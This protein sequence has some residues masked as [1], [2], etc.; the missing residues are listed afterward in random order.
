MT[1]SLPASVPTEGGVECGSSL[2]F[3]YRMQV[4]RTGEIETFKEFVDKRLQFP[5]CEDKQMIALYQ[6]TT[7]NCSLSRRSLSLFP[8]SSLH[9]LPRPLF[10][11]HLP[12]LPSWNDSRRA[13]RNQS[14]YRHAID[15]Y[16]HDVSDRSCNPLRLSLN[17]LSSH[18]FTRRFDQSKDSRSN[19]IEPSTHL[20]RSSA[21]VKGPNSRKIL[22][23]LRTRL[24]LVKD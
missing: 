4:S 12:S 5:Y 1:T 22:Q 15:N 14:I 7:G 16:L 17:C 23:I 24:R 9:P 3:A 8:C 20:P 11:C 18:F 19:R 10:H 21:H 13:K 2:E 6:I